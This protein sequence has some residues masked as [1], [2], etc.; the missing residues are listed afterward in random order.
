MLARRT[1]GTPDR[2]D[3]PSAVLLGR[4][5]PNPLRAADLLVALDPTFQRPAIAGFFL[6]PSRAAIRLPQTADTFLPT[7]EDP[8]EGGR[9]QPVSV[10]PASLAVKNRAPLAL[11]PCSGHGPNG[12]RSRFDRRSSHG[13][14]CPCW[15][16]SALY[17]LSF[18]LCLT[19]FTMKSRFR[20]RSRRC[21]NS[22][23]LISTWTT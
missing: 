7:E 19:G 3:S 18:L 16:A 22:W 20:L 4:L 5:A 12:S 23:H 9:L 8:S 14:S 1:Q 15:H 21:W 13:M 11:H 10:Y 17:F 2:P 6:R